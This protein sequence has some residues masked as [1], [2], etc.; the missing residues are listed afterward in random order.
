MQHVDGFSGSD[1]VISVNVNDTAPINEE[2]D[3][4]AVGDAEQTVDALIKK[5]G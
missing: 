3:L 2:T 1:Y 5:L 4:I